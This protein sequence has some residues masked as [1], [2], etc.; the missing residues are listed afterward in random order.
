[1]S[2]LLNEFINEI[3]SEFSDS[4]VKIYVNNY[5]RKN[6]LKKG[7]LDMYFSSEESLVKLKDALAKS[8]MQGEIENFTLNSSHLTIHFERR[9][10]CENVIK[11][12]HELEN[13][14]GFHMCKAKPV[15]TK[16]VK[17][18][19]SDLTQLRQKLFNHQIKQLLALCGYEVNNE[20]DNST[21]ECHV[22]KVNTIHSKT[23]STEELEECCTNLI[24]KS[25][26]HKFKQLTADGEKE[27]DKIHAS[28]LD[29]CIKFN[30][31]YASPKRSIVLDLNENNLNLI[32]SGSFVMY[33]YARLA[34][35][36]H[37]FDDLVQSHQYP[38]M[39]EINEVQFS[40]L[41]REEEW[42]LIRDYLMYFPYVV[43]E[44]ICEIGGHPPVHKVSIFINKMIFYII[45]II[46]IIVQHDLFLYKN[47]SNT[48]Y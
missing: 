25:A 33:N 17:T 1:M 36:I 7:D 32:K 21:T 28:T 12:I 8:C 2:Y 43:N 41:R 24:I 5:S 34:S 3:N 38:P 23:S 20:K 27:V 22:G 10:V 46:I 39:A 6:V 15:I 16:D 48:F 9:A 42:L 35:I 44:V 19:V 31:L 26:V 37:K 30:L 47:S 11:Q 40:L 18:H 13:N 4:S 45:I 14:Y 29:A